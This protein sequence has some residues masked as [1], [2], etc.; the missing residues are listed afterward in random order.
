MRLSLLH[1]AE[2]CHGEICRARRRL[3]LIAPGQHVATHPPIL[4]CSESPR[5]SI[6]HDAAPVHVRRRLRAEERIGQFALRLAGTSRLLA[7]RCR[8]C[9]A[10]LTAPGLISYRR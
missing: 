8:L 3:P 5:Q 2:A 7:A 6:M 4:E 10:A 1:L 9:H